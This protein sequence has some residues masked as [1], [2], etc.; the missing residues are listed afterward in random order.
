MTGKQS[1]VLWLGLLLVVLRMFSSGQWNIL[2]GTTS[3]LGYKAPGSTPSN[4]ATHSS[5]EN[6]ATGSLTLKA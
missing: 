4:T 5:A 1:A 6:G 2:W 3:Q